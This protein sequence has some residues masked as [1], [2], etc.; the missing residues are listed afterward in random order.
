M[1]GLTLKEKAALALMYELPE[2]KAFKRWCLVKR[3]KVAELIIQTDMSSPGAAEQIAMLQGQAYA[4]EMI[5][6]EWQKY[7]K[8]DID[9]AVKEKGW[10][11]FCKA[12]SILAFR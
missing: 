12:E 1:A 10:Y 11:G 7:H 2:F 6:L 9:K 5:L 8:Q 4:L 3:Q